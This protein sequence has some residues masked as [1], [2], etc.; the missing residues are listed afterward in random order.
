MGEAGVTED[1]VGRG[2][3]GRGQT[4][5]RRVEWWGTVHGGGL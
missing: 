1:Y 5:R 4:W 2:R 3:S